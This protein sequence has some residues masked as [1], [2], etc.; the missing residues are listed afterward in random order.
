M[1]RA[2]LRVIHARHVAEIVAWAEDEVEQQAR[3]RLQQDG[4]VGITVSP[5]VA[6]GRLVKTGGKDVGDDGLM[7]LG[8]GALLLFRGSGEV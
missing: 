4:S 5:Q 1:A 8:E 3:F 6:I 7:G 2:H